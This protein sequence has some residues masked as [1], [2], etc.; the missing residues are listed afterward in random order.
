MPYFDD[1]SEE[2]LS[3]CREELQRPLRATIQYMRFSIKEGSEYKVKVKILLVDKT[4][5]YD[6]YLLAGRILQ[7]ADLM[8]ISIVWGGINN[9]DHFKLFER[10]RV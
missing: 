10:E 7:S 1:K 2:E 6:Y 5:Y 9:A 4:N 8:G 3:K